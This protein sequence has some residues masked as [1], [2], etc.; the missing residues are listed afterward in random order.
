MKKSIWIVLMMSF[1]VG[2]GI[3][4]TDAPKVE[5]GKGCGCGGKPK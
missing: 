1:L 2:V 3:Y 5:H 4:V